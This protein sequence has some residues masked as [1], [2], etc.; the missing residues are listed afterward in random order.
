MLFE[1]H[2]ELRNHLWRGQLWNHSYY[3]E[4]VGDV[5]EETIRKYIERQSKAY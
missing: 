2:P 1:R 3:V 4:T 5:S